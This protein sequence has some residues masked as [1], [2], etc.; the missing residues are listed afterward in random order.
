MS[1]T[2]LS[3]PIAGR[4]TRSVHIQRDFIDLDT[5]LEGYQVTPLV[6]A[7]LERVV[8]SLAPNA[9]GRAFSIIGPY[10]SGKS[11]FGLFLASYLQSTPSKREQ[12][13]PTSMVPGT[14]DSSLYE[15]PQLL[16]VIVSGNNSSLR[17][18]LLRSLHDAL[19]TISR[20]RV[21]IKNIVASLTRAFADPDI[22]PE[23]VASLIETVG[24]AVKQYSS[25]DGLLIIVDELGQHLDYAAQGR[26]ERDLFVLQTVAE[27]SARSGDIP[28]LF[29]TILHQSF[30]RYAGSAGAH[31]RAEWAKVQGRFIDIPFNEPAS[32]LIRMVA[33]AL[34]IH[35]DD[36][37]AEARSD[38][39][40]QV[41]PL[42]EQ[43]NLRPKDISTYD[44][45]ELVAQA[46]PIHPMV[47]VALPAI[48]R[49]LAQNER[50]LFAFLSTPEP[51]SLQDV[52]RI[53]TA[54]SGT[55]PIYRMTHL[56]AYIESSLGLSLFHQ[57]RGRR[58]SELA[59][60]RQR[61]EHFD[62]MVDDVLVTIGT[63]NALG[64][65]Q[66]LRASSNHLSFA[67]Q[68]NIDHPDVLRALL[69]LQ[70]RQHITYRHHRDSYALFE[71]S[72]LDL[73]TIIQ[74]ELNALGDQVSS[75]DLLQEHASTT[76]FIARRH[77]YETGAV[78]HFSVR[79]VTDDELPRYLAM[80][81]IGD[82]EIFYILP[83]DIEALERVMEL[84]RHPNRQADAQRILVISNHVQSLRE[85]LL[86]VSAVG[87]VLA[88]EPLLENDRVARREL[89]SRLSD[90]QQALAD[91]LVQAYGPG[92]SHWYWQGSI[93]PIN[94]MRDVDALLS[95]ICDEV[96]SLTP[97]IWN[98]LINR[99]QLTAMG[100]KARRNLVEAMLDYGHIERVGLIGYP[101]ERAIYESVFLNSGLHRQDENGQWI[102]AEPN[103]TNSTNLRPVW[104]A[105]HRF[106]DRTAD[107]PIDLETLYAL[108]E[109]PP[110]GVKAGL[111]PLLF[112]AAY[113]SNAGEMVLY[114]NGNYVQVPSIAVFE[115][116][117]R[118]P[119]HFSL[120]LSRI[121]G[122]RLTIY[123]RI[124]H[125][126]APKKA[127]NGS[128]PLINDAATPLMRFIAKLP[129][130][131]QNT[132]TISDQAKAVRK[133]I[134]AAQTPDQLLFYLLPQ[135]CN[136][137]PFIAGNEDPKHV[138]TFITSLREYLVEIQ[139]AYPN[140]VQN[141]VND[142]RKAFKTQQES[143]MLLREELAERYRFISGVTS[144]IQL[145][146]FGVRVEN[147]SNDAGWVESIGAL[148][149]RK[150]TTSWND[151]DINSFTAQIMDLGRRFQ[152]A[153]HL[154]VAIAPQESASTVLRIGLTNY[155]GE[156]SMVIHTSAED[157][158]I[159]EVHQ[160]IMDVLNNYPM[161]VP[162]QQVRVLSMLL[163]P[164]L[165]HIK[166]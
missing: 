2:T 44:W 56:Y 116:L 157:D 75:T 19:S 36:K 86:E 81:V 48:F 103:A 16:P 87:H 134:L 122:S 10:G 90:A 120:R 60:A 107:A 77:S 124:I 67:L 21:P 154:A 133:A 53:T 70:S 145:R 94:N 115:R 69:Q 164:L 4:Y 123:E 59:E 88:S 121:R 80:P 12:L 37:F 109:K 101:P 99:R 18:A 138:D 58:W 111:I 147:G 84:L 3:L 158:L 89:A 76:P 96:F 141:L 92:S 118:Q 66:T 151:N 117:L 132:H 23:S 41:L 13:L 64:Q 51:W 32:Q 52:L 114:E 54:I 104:D 106:F 57:T 161:L 1:N 108:L 146:A 71:G 93:Q 29:V 105:I 83:S 47:L 97:R 142:I 153:E 27:M 55:L 126:L 152:D 11:A 162:A 38:W 43:L 135:A 14:I 22:D 85:L 156:R 137:P 150:P 26:G 98:E 143:F 163:N 113:L 148:L 25:W 102:I 125:A 130:F 129:E 68:D 33:H 45:A 5:S 139:D 35:G 140:L 82:G 65:N 155:Q 42:T 149:I 131:S 119:G 15:V 7:T 24:N 128:I 20:Q 50:S 100:A 46:Y 74:H 39:V 112:I 95:N 91:V 63:L 127:L 160:R 165:D 31:Q 17:L 144:D 61:I 136:L 73:D 72:D 40:R 6:V 166:E 79:F 110:Y 49:Q 34:S 78:R 28:C 9:K 30:E 8:A 159:D 62:S